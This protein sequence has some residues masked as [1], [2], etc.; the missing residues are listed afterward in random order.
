MEY[1]MY[2]SRGNAAR[3]L[4]KSQCG[5]KT[6]FS[7]KIL[8]LQGIRTVHSPARPVRTKTDAFCTPTGQI[9]NDFLCRWKYLYALEKGGSARPILFPQK[10]LLCAGSSAIFGIY[11]E[12]SQKYYNNSMKH[13][14][15][16]VRNR[17]FFNELLT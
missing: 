10:S 9:G 16:Q 8:V 3:L 12:N 5:E 1:L 15:L 6:I 14:V 2:D 11:A 17:T 13:A 7:G 4:Q